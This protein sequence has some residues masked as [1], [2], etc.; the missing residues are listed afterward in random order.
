MSG[1]T[2]L[3]NIKL[4]GDLVR[5]YAP[6]LSFTM[7]EIGA[8]QIAGQQEPFYALLELFP[9]SKLI[10][11][12]VDA[13]SC[14]ELNKTAP[15]YIC[16]YPTAIGGLNGEQTLYETLGPECSSLY[17]PNDALLN[18]YNALEQVA[19]KAEHKLLVSTLD[20]FIEENNI[21]SID[22]IKIDI[23]GAELDA[24]KGGVNAL[25]DTVFIVSEV[26][27]I[28]L[29]ENQ[30]L[31]GDVCKFLSSEGLMFHKFLGLAGRSIKPVI[32]QNNINFGTQHMWSD[33]VY[34]KDI[35]KL[36]KVPPDSLLKLALLA[37]LYGSPDVTYHCFELYD[38]LKKTNLLQD[39][40]NKVV[41]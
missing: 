23:Q 37:T 38:E 10:G 2:E 4:V 29:Y 31:F 18:K 15:P 11:F 30:P 20:S 36:N 32:L 7:C 27:F 28:P 40:I 21:G 8:R 17:K 9:E 33:A 39:F 3:N 41:N 22:F 13:E 24:F 6:E 26:E 1:N 34:I 35:E 25:K 16:Y 19:V 14:K 5:Q 12:E